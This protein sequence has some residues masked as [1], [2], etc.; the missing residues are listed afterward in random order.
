MRRALAVVSAWVCLGVGLWAQTPAGGELPPAETRAALIEAERRAKA[1]ALTPEVVSTWERRMLAL[2][3]RNFPQSL[4]AGEYNGIRTLIGGMPS[5][6]GFVGGVG[7]MRGATGDRLR[8]N[9]SARISTENYR[10]LDAEAL[11]PT[12]RSGRPF[13]VRIHSRYAD[14]RALDL[15]GLGQDSS[16]DARGTYRFESR[17]VAV[18]ASSR[19]GRLISV[20]AEGGLLDGSVRSFDGGGDR[21]PNL[22][23]ASLQPT[24][25]FGGGHVA[26]TLRDHALR[27]AGVRLSLDATRWVDVDTDLFD[28][29]RLIGEL[30]A[31]LPLGAR[32]RMLAFHVRTSYSTADSGARVPFYLMET[33]GGA[34]SIRGFDEYRFRDTRNVVANAEYRWEIWNYADVAIFGDVGRVFSDADD[35]TW[36]GFAAGYGI[37]LRSVLPGGGGFRIDLARGREGFR[38]HI[39]GGPSF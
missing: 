13:Q 10:Q 2:E 29:T 4:F 23:G 18:S 11:F 14:Y 30:Q 33:I 22:P 19:A 12:T 35:F 8:F 39:G 24:F 3:A 37:G 31:H 16:P 5:G 9:A 32:N 26:L 27:F 28:F 6:S 21:F 17:T 36:S 7:Y 1:D 38:L 34:K 15:Y 25:V 20:G